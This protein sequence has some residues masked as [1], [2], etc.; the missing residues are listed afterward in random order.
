MYI[1]KNKLCSCTSYHDILFKNGG[2]GGA[3]LM[4]NPAAGATQKGTPAPAAWGGE[5]RFLLERFPWSAMWA[6]EFWKSY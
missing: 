3:E 6:K 4:D 2:G 5:N 1:K